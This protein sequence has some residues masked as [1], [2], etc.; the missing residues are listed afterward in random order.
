MKN[1]ITHTYIVRLDVAGELKL[2]KLHITNEHCY[3]ERFNKG[4]QII[5]L[6]DNQMAAALISQ[7]N[8]LK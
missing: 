1:Q 2:V 5:S 8:K 7:Q 6:I 4:N 3:I